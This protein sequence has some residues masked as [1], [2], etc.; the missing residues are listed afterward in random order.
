MVFVFLLA[1]VFG[2]G[3]VQDVSAQAFPSFPTGCTSALGYSVTN[4]TPCNGT[5]FATMNIAGCSTAL[6]YSIT[7]GAPCS[8]ISVAIPYLAGCTSI[9]SYSTISGV[10]CNGTSVAS[11][12]S[13]TPLPIPGLP[14]TGAGGNAF[15]NM[16]LLLSSGV[17]ALMG[18]IY[19]IRKSRIVV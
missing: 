13:S 12:Q 4:G 8:G 18:S 3:S 2:F 6:G 7:T 17:V 9:Y 16:M 19:F 11:V 10:A 5:S 1:L 14:T 15:T